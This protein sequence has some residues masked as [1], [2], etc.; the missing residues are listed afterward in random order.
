MSIEVR[1]V[2]KHQRFVVRELL[3]AIQSRGTCHIGR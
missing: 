2:G 3:H 1:H